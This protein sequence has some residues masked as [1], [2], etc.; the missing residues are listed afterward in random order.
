MQKKKK[1]KK[2]SRIL[3]HFR[4]PITPKPIESKLSTLLDSSRSYGRLLENQKIGDSR[5]LF[6]PENDFQTSSIKNF[7]KKHPDFGRLKTN[8]NHEIQT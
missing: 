4:M 3:L 2:K 5:E 7:P 8:Q 1:K 6:L